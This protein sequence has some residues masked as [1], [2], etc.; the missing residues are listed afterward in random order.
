MG[1][2]IKNFLTLTDAL[3]FL[4]EN[5]KNSQAI[6]NNIGKKIYKNFYFDY[7]KKDSF[8]KEEMQE[9]IDYSNKNS[10]TKPVQEFDLDMN[11]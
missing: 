4:N 10:Q 8:S 1:N 9:I 3:K 6:K 11:L 7:N 5:P 2:Y